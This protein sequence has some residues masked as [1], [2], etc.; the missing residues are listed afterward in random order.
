MFLAGLSQPHAVTE[1]PVPLENML[2]AA[3]PGEV[4]GAR[5]RPE[6]SVGELD[7]DWTANTAVLDCAL[8]CGPTRIR[9][10]MRP[11]NVRRPPNPPV[12]AHQ[13]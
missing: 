9:P 5:Q 13:L 11:F 4:C 1:N 6:G 12:A 3:M 8:R 7:G 2:S 10:T